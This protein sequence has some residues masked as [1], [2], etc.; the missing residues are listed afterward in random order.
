MVEPAAPWGDDVAWGR[1]SSSFFGQA[2]FVA[3]HAKLVLVDD[4]Q[5]GA[6]RAGQQLV[7]AEA[8]DLLAGVVDVGNAQLAALAG[9]FDHGRRALGEM[10]VRSMAR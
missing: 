10:M 5:A 2:G 6:A 4:Q 9:V 8:D 7:A 1:A 3:D